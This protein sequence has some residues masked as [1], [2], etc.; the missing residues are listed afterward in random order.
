MIQYSSQRWQGKTMGRYQLLHLVGKGGMGEVWLAED[1]QLRRQV[2]IKMLPPVLAADTYYLQSFEHEARTAAALEHPHI[3][4]VHDFGFTPA[5]DNSVVT[6]IV[7]PYIDGGSLRERIKAEQGLLPTEESLNYLTQA[8]LAIDY[9]HTQRVIHRDIKPGNMLLQQRWLLLSDFGIAKL[10]QTTIDQS[11]TNPAAGTPEYMAP[12]QVQG[13]A[14]PASD[15]YSLG[16]I[17]YQLFTGKVP[18]KGSSVLET[19]MLQITTAPPPA[20][21]F[22]A[23]LP[24]QVEAVLLQVLAKQPEQRPASCIEFVNLLSQAWNIRS[25]DDLDPDAT[26]L[27]PWNKRKQQA[28]LLQQEQQAAA[29]LPQQQSD[30]HA[31]E[32]AV[33]QYEQSANIPGY[34]P[35]FAAQPISM[36][37]ETEVELEPAPKKGTSR[38]AFIIGG[39]AAVAVIVAGGV[40]A[41]FIWKAIHPAPGPQELVPGKAMFLLTGHN[42]A[43]QDAVWDPQSLYLLTTGDDDSVLLWDIATPA[44]K[45]SGKFSRQTISTPTNKW[46][47]QAE[48]GIGGNEIDFSADSKHVVIVPLFSDTIYVADTLQQDGTLHKYTEKTPDAP[49]IPQYDN[50]AWRSGSNDTFAVMKFPDIGANDLV[51]AEIWRLSNTSKPVKQLSLAANANAQYKYLS[52]IRW[53]AK[54]KYLSGTGNSSNP[55]PRTLKTIV[56]DGDTGQIVAKL[57]WPKRTW[58][59]LLM[60]SNVSVPVDCLWSPIGEDTLAIIDADAAI[61]YNVLH[62]KVLFSFGTDDKRPHNPPNLSKYKKNW[63]AVLNGVA[64]SPNGRYLAGCYTNDDRVYIWDTQQESSKRRVVGGLIMPIMQFGDVQGH[65]MSTTGLAWSPD[66]KYIATT[67]YDSTVIVWK[68]DAA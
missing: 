36:T 6:Y 14:V 43:V 17:A 65:T 59:P 2:A 30:E 52:G 63:V 61:V 38:R 18:F 27:A 57:S 42:R 48:S 39:A 28:Q 12:E 20:R 35:N 25:S 66:G 10:L 33:N 24:E 44:S 56:W 22:N 31:S 15:L 55:D 1:P 3:L 41:P 50:A 19:M 40:S 16:I 49:S 34:D 64:W 11:Q 45:V 51:C 54:G 67:S 21:A 4:T 37:G 47:F 60:Q 8:A 32:T 58:N 13:H 68:V 5:E 26:V 7:T 29:F 23:H 46:K 9:A 53:S 62:N